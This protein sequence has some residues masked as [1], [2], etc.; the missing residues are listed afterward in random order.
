MLARPILSCNYNVL[1]SDCRSLRRNDALRRVRDLVLK[2]TRKWAVQRACK[3]VALASRVL[4][5]V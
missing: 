2:K 4:Y 3:S 1:T 5:R